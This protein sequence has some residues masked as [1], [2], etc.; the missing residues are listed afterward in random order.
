MNKLNTT[1]GGLIIALLFPIIAVQAQTEAMTLSITP[2]LI[3]NNVAPGQVWKSQVKLVNNNPR[4]LTAYVQVKDF[5]GRA[6]N[7]TV[8]FLEMEGSPEDNPHMLS[9]WIDVL[10]DSVEIPAYDSREIEFVI[11]VP[12]TAAP[13]GHYAAILAGNSPPDEK[14]E[15]S[16]IKVSSLLASLLL[17]NVKGDVVERGGIREFST[18]K[19]F[20]SAPEVQFTMAFSNEGNTHLQ[21]R[22]EIK[23]LNLFNKEKGVITINH[24][25]N[26][27]NVLP[28]ET[29]R[30]TFDWQGESNLLDMGR[31]RADLVL[32]FGE[33]NGRQTVDQ[34]VYFWLIY[35][36]PLLIFIGSILLLVLLAMFFIRRSVRQAVARSQETI[37]MLTQHSNTADDQAKAAAPP[38][39]MPAASDNLNWSTYRVFITALLVFC[40][41]LG[42]G[43]ALVYM[44]NQNPEQAVRDLGDAEANP[45]IEAHSPIDSEAVVSQITPEADEEAEAADNEINQDIRIMILNGSGASGAAGAV[46]GLINEL[47]FLDTDTGNA[48]SYDY[49]ATEIYF[50]DSTDKAAAQ[51]IA[52]AINGTTIIRPRQDID[53]G[54]EIIV[55]EEYR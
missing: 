15:G 43:M 25:T 4:P 22:G 41:L 54:I 28:G 6:E 26:T 36:Q 34:T 50:K 1:I 52:E 38:R 5:Q 23:V 30:W 49:G 42:I 2:P 19:S 7:G 48:D 47:G 3:K 17:V 27:G 20:Y 8:E 14:I 32:G 39:P 35:W 12:E 37:G 46:E 18:D 9:A 29:R 10:D 11:Q 31:Y 44:F 33:E 13:G 45:G 24:G 16:A 40:L 21:P 53:S 51:Q 55:G